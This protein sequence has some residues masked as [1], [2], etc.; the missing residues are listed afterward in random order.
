MIPRQ[1]SHLNVQT[2]GDESLVLDLSCDQIHQLNATATWIFQHCDGH[3]SVEDL[4]DELAEIYSIERDRAKT[5]LRQTI[6]QLAALNL[7]EFTGE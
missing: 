3:T 5:D 6:E 4:S 7:I 2:V 1:R